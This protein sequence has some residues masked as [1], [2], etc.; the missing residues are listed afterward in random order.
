VRK[1][2]TTRYLSGDGP[3]R[4]LAMALFARARILIT[5]SPT[6][7]HFEGPHGSLRVAPELHLNNLG[8]IE[9]VGKLPAE[10]PPM[11][12][13]DVF[14]PQ[15]MA[16]NRHFQ[17]FLMYGWYSVG[18]KASDRWRFVL[19]PHVQVA[20]LESLAGVGLTL[21]TVR[22]ALRAAGASRVTRADDGR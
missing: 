20:G 6:E 7:V 14:S 13:I 1:Y 9:A 10:A 3:G 5:F 16:P 19:R 8:R 4:I 17:N 18:R 12:R 2:S 22:R 15:A 21:E 11:Q